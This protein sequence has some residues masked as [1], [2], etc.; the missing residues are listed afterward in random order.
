[1]QPWPV[2]SHY[3]WRL[4]KT[5]RAMA[6]QRSIRLEN[7]LPFCMNQRYTGTFAHARF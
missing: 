1:M 7:P 6:R 3:I 5:K 2:L 4:K